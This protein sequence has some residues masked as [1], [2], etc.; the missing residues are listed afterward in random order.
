MHEVFLGGPLCPPWADGAA[1]PPPSPA[2]YA[3]AMSD[4]GTEKPPQGL[5]VAIGHH[6]CARALIRGGSGKE[7]SLTWRTSVVLKTREI[8]G[9]LR[10]L[11]R[12]K[13]SD[14]TP[15]MEH[16]DALALLSATSLGCVRVLEH[17]GSYLTFG[18][19]YT[20]SWNR[21]LL[22]ACRSRSL[23][24]MKV[25]SQDLSVLSCLRWDS[26]LIPCE[27]MALMNDRSLTEFDV[28][29]FLLAARTGDLD[30]LPKSLAG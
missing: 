7:P 21:I 12:G 2:V 3:W 10:Y 22:E 9:C 18:R 23:E 4:D 15:R 30:T 6:Q 26:H 16:R 24:I 8:A 11:R 14:S 20:I 25:R 1:T 28:V 5:G 19:S 27:Q 13:L 17:M 29:P